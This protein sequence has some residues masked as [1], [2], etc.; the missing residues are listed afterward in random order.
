MLILLVEPGLQLNDRRHLFA[1]LGGPPQRPNDRGVFPD[2]VKRLLD[3]E[4]V[5]II[6]RRVQKIHDHSER[7]V[8]V[9]QEHVPLAD[10]RKDILVGGKP[11][12][13]ARVEGRVLM[14]RVERE[15]IQGKE[16]TDID[17]AIDFIDKPL[18]NAELP[19]EEI[20]DLLWERRARF[21][22]GRRFCPSD[23]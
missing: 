6:G 12:R 13:D 1:V 16:I 9:V 15:F 2:P 4:H 10:D 7:V 23:L 17:R 14:G 18:L 21:R 3:R 5:G 20:D 11:L 8:G 22:A 19:G